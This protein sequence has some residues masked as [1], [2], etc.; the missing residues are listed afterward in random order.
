[1]IYS[2]KRFSY[3]GKTSGAFVGLSAGAFL[4][5][6]IEKKIIDLKHSHSYSKDKLIKLLENEKKN[7][8]NNLKDAE[9][10]KKSDP[11]GYREALPDLDFSENVDL[12]KKEISKINSEQKKIRTNPEYG[13]RLWDNFKP[14]TSGKGSVIGGTL[15]SIGGFLGGHYIDKKFSS[16]REY[17]LQEALKTRPDLDL[18]K[19]TNKETRKD[20]EDG[21]IR[22]TR[23]KNPGVTQKRGVKK[24]KPAGTKPI[25]WENRREWKPTPE[26]QK[27]AKELKLS[28]KKK[29]LKQGGMIAAGTIGVAGL[30]YGGK[31]IYDKIKMNRELREYRKQFDTPKCNI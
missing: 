3:Q 26:I 2:V 22:E 5:D 4:G 6:K 1:M 17:D 14:G 15:G 29:N 18:S 8:L 23:S 30:A 25:S 11:K 27:R 12:L 10:W 24:N 19:F 9:E 7:Y 31:K 13:K 21:L 28:K 20:V 16:H